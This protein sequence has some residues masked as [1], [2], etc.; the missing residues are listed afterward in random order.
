MKIHVQRIIAVGILMCL[1]PD[2][3][4]A[5]PVT[6]AWKAKLIAKLPSGY[7]QGVN[8]LAFS[9]DGKML[10]S[11]GSFDNTI[12]LWDIAGRKNTTTFKP[13]GDFDVFALLSFSPDSKTL[14]VAGYRGGTSITVWDV[15]SGKEIMA[16][17]RLRG[18]TALQFSKDGRTLAA[19]ILDKVHLWDVPSYKERAVVQLKLDL[20]Y[21]VKALAFM[22]DGKL[23]ALT[24]GNKSLLVYEINGDKTNNLAL[25]SSSSSVRRCLFSPDQMYVAAVS[26][27]YSV[28]L[29][30]VANGKNIASYE[31]PYQIFDLVY[32]PNGKILALSSWPIRG[33]KNSP[34]RLLN[35]H[36]GTELETLTVDKAYLVAQTFSP[37]GLFLAAADKD[38]IYLW[39][40]RAVGNPGK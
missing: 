32:H 1:M 15:S 2:F 31:K 19:G 27:M 6:S 16:V 11:G 10:A 30:D 28:R 39:D 20:G 26:S 7:R 5:A 4:F 14:A 36:T 12:K 18:V 24:G 37:D 38:N 9:P 21:V 17:K 34:I 3:S 33:V 35:V 29:W 40:I 13:V 25:E 23:L 22:P 8:R